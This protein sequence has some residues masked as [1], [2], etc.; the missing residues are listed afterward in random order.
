MIK[1]KKGVIFINKNHMCC[2]FDLVKRHGL[3][4]SFFQ[5]EGY[6][7]IKG[8]ISKEDFN[9]MKEE[10]KK[11]KIIFKRADFSYCELIPNKSV[12]PIYWEE[13]KINSITSI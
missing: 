8:V 12:K 7:E 13:S 6:I 4:G 3:S 11:N 1:I 10:I 9:L 2:G 5:E